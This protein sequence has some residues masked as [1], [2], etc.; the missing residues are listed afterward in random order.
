MA[1]KA[2]KKGSAVKSKEKPKAVKTTSK[3]AL[4]ESAKSAAPKANKSAGKEKTPA[5]EKAARAPKLTA[6]EDGADEMTEAVEAAPEKAPKPPKVPKVPKV[7]PERISAAQRKADKAAADSTAHWSD[8][9]QKHN[10]EKPQVY[11]MKSQFEAHKPLQHKVL[12]WGWIMSVE[13]DRL[14]V[15]FQDGKRMLISN[16]K[17][18]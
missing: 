13:N 2:A 12:G 1:K 9:H 17:P 11:D 10:S 6:V 14:E 8:L 7:K 16:Y 15:I 5:A 3:V 18:R 4:K